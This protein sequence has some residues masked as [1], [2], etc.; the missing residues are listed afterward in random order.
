MSKRSLFVGAVVCALLTGV[1]LGV[2]W[3]PVVT[4]LKYINA[5]TGEIE[6]ETVFMGWTTSASFNG[7]RVLSAPSLGMPSLGMPSLS[8]PATGRYLIKHRITNLC[9]WTFRREELG[10][11]A[12]E[13]EQ[14]QHEANAAWLEANA[15]KLEA[16]S[17]GPQCDAMVGQDDCIEGG[18]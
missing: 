18:E 11:L 8:V 4:E 7:D 2:L 1:V 17:K 16:A 6:G 9:G 12:P 3:L 10:L 5:A 14:W 13:L 15:D